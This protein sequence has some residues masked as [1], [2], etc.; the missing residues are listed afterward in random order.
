[1]T[2]L[3]AFGMMSF[4]TAQFDDIYFDP[5]NADD[6]YA[7]VE[8]KKYI[9]KSTYESTDEAG[10]QYDYYYTSRMRRF[11]NPYYGFDFYSPVYVDPA[12][13]NPYYSNFY[14]PGSSIYWGGAAVPTSRPLTFVS[15]GW[16][17][18]TYGVPVNAWG[19]PVNTWGTPVG[20]WGTP[21]A[22]PSSVNSFGGASFGGVGAA[23]GVGGY[24]AY[25]PPSYY[26][27]SSI[28]AFNNPGVF[29][30]SN[31]TAVNPNPR[32]TVSQGTVYGPRGS[33]GTVT[34]SPRNGR[35]GSVSAPDRPLSTG[36][37]NS[38][39]LSS[40]QT[41]TDVRN[42]RESYVGSPRSSRESYA[43]PRGTSSR[44]TFTRTDAAKSRFNSSSYTRPSRPS[45]SYRSSGSDFGR[46][47]STF[48]RSSSSSSRSSFRSSGSSSRS[49]SSPRSS[50]G[51]S[52][53]SSP[54]GGRG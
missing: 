35:T 40:R 4:A 24:N 27:N 28:G 54:R 13:Y 29:T 48:N 45:N 47:N 9:D 17:Y 22:F 30:G 41:N 10:D 53:S 33:S 38:S 31:N 37:I 32:G 39:A 15:T 23:G 25:C 8:L 26:T 34:T 14:R 5:D 6:I 50:G 51:A 20:S 42:S 16:G 46:S 3:L 1:M 43:P 49:Y 12:Y 52:R 21:G 2:A 19:Q 36:T 44:N 7:E 18:S 11:D